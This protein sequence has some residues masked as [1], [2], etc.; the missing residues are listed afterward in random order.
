LFARRCREVR[1]EGIAQDHARVDWQSKSARE[2]KPRTVT[3][4]ARGD[5]LRACARELRAC[6]RDVEGDANASL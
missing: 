4:V 6:A 2:I 5:Q 1:G 3:L